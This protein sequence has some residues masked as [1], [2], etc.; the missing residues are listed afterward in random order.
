[1]GFINDLSVLTTVP[2]SN[3]KNLAEKEK[4]CIC[5]KV[6]EN[7]LKGEPITH[8]DL[9]FG[10]LYIMHEGDELKYKFIPSK[11]LE[12]DLKTTITTGKSPLIGKVEDTL[13]EKILN[14]YKDLF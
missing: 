5:H 10:A 12:S 2:V 11:A 8:I 14:A 13:K 3:L 6:F 9:E 1:M 7:E 4:L